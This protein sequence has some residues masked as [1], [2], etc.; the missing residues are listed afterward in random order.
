MAEAVLLVPDTVL[1]ILGFGCGWN[2]AVARDSDPRF[3]GRHF[4]LPAV[5]PDELPFWVASA[6]VALVVLPPVSFNQ[7]YTTPNK[8][9]E[10]LAAGTPMVLGP[11]LP[12]M[13]GILERED[14]GRIAASM[15]PEAI[16]DAIRSILELPIDERRS[17]RARLASAARGR[18]LQLADRRSRV[19]ETVLRRVEA[20]ETA[21]QGRPCRAAQ[22]S[23]HVVGA[24]PNFM[25][26]APVIRALAARGV[27][28]AGPHRPA[29]RRR[30]VGGVLPRPRPA[31]AGRRSRR[32]LRVARR[33]DR[34]DH[35]RARAGVR[36][37]RPALVVVYGDVN[38]T[39]AAALVARRSACR[40]P[41]SRP[42]CE[43]STTR[44]PRRSTGAS[45]TSSPSSCS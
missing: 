23:S 7:R 42:A 24:R 9:L 22:W 13:A 19:H 17:W 2:V 18:A 20:L 11:D 3:A 5:H 16:A 27:P 14:A 35:G 8:F 31:P 6:D 45:P 12:T 15:E 28:A 43:A 33:P 29:L 30:P 4:T 1:V 25:K 32:R 44:C 40:W 26:A 34:G 21:Q 37:I 36:E 38:S 41:T 10:A 39:V